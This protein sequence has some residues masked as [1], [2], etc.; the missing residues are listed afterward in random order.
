MTRE[1]TYGRKKVMLNVR[2]WEKKKKDGEKTTEQGKWCGGQRS[3]LNK[4]VWQTREK[5]KNG[6]GTGGGP[7]KKGREE[8]SRVT[9]KLGLRGIENRQLGEGS[10]LL[11]R[12]KKRDL[13]GGLLPPRRE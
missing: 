11:C 4:G 2:R 3:S 5:H 9:S 8:W 6:Q 1:E 12:Q 10:V 13:L 7:P